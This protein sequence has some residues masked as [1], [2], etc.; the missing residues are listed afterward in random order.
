MEDREIVLKL[1]GMS[2]A[3]C[4][5]RIEKALQKLDVSV[6]C[7]VNF[8]SEEAVVSFNE[9]R[10]NENQ[11]VREVKRIGYAAKVKEE[12]DLEVDDESR[13]LLFSFLVSFCLSLPM[14]LGMTLGIFGVSVPLFH[15]FVFQLCCTIPIQFVGGFRFLK[16]A[17]KG[18]LSLNP[19][20]DL[21]VAAGT[22]SAFFY[23]VY[24]GIA[25][26][27]GAHFYF[28][29]SAMVI[30]LVL[31]GKYLEARAKRATRGAIRKLME[32]T[33]KTA[34]VRREG[35][36]IAIEVEKVIAGDLVIVRPGEKIPVDG[37]V[38]EGSSSVD[39]SMITGESMSVDKSQG[40]KVV[41]GTI[42]LYGTLVFRA[43]KVGDER[44]LSQLIRLIEK[45]QS[46]KAP[47]QKMADRV[48]NIFVPA[49]LVVAAVTFVV[50]MLA[51][52][53]LEQALLSAVSVLVVACPCAL[54]LA[55]PTAIIVGTGKGASLGI[56]IKNGES[57][58]TA[59]KVDTVVFD[60]TGTLTK[61]EPEVAELLFLSPERDCFLR[62]A[63][64]MELRSEHPVGC[65]I[66]NYAVQ[67]LGGEEEILSPLEFEA[68]P[69]AGVR[70]TFSDGRSF[71]AGKAAFLLEENIPLSSSQREKIKE[72]ETAGK[73]AIL[74]SVNGILI[75]G[76][77]VADA[78]KE[79]TPE[80]VA[81]LKKE[82][83]EVWMLS[84]D[85][86]GTAQRI[87]MLS[88]IQNIAANL[89]PQEKGELIRR[90]RGEGKT[91][92]M[93]GDG[94]ND[95][96][97]LV[98]ADVGI[99]V[100]TGTDIAAESSDITLISGDLLTVDTALQ[101][102]NRMMRKIRQ[103][104]FW[105]FFYNV[106]SMP[107]AALGLLNPMIC[108]GAMAFSSVSVVLNSLSIYLFRKK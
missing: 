24:V 2:C 79:S 32:L 73:S 108:A 61:G 83:K 43:E 9:E 51:G 31:L 41:G 34:H 95:A 91:V 64:G 87:G 66:L 20:M 53:G 84:G 80:A 68:V 89:K 71:L 19:G 16:N 14:L 98:E 46:S 101:L 40:S 26:P 90:L 58:E 81:R 59:G 18:L 69:G 12:R 44:F 100:G 49:V 27:A 37:T 107:S 29:S 105:A 45:A 77:A 54:G 50:W 67:Q 42:N 60:K 28:D 78:I 76:A 38:T 22:L 103:N 5:S 3:V 70:G 93:V 88:G 75:G 33:P 85:N 62:L 63:G 6:K 15:H 36:E 99:A 23:S 47:I 56:L 8:A 11:L 4:A 17:V 21:L 52:G 96:L 35:K 106:I 102:A 94:I 82:G 74:F 65:A 104:L 1:K 57:L 86:A 97:A 92:A 72:L 10:V 48:A 39:E 13:R 7:S 30:T 25:S 55:T